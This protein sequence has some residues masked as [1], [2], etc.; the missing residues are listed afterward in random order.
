M[1]SKLTIAGNGNRVGSDSDGEEGKGLGEEVH[2]GVDVKDGAGGEG[3]R[4]TVSKQ[5]GSVTDYLN[6][7]GAVVM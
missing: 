4:R 1:G 5:W 3:R 7:F 6:D 2:Y